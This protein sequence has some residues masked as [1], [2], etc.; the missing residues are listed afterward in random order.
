MYDQI[1]NQLSRFITLDKEEQEYF[2]N[3]LVVKQFK[4]KELILQQGQVCNYTYFINKGCLRYYYL[5]EGKENTAQFFFENGWY[6]DFESF[7][8]GKPSHQN[9]ETLE[10]TELLMLSSKHIQQ[11][12]M[13]VPKFE[14]FGRQMAEHAFLGIRGRTEMLENLSAE[15][16]YLKL[17]K[18]RPKVVERIPQHYIASYLGVQPESLSRIR[19]RISNQR[20]S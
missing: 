6:T 19:N 18:E 20:I 16:R 3:M 12:Y 9:I 5:V 2:I 11:L 13:D 7:L 15:E 8:S 4:K 17:L 10:K 1:L 14:R